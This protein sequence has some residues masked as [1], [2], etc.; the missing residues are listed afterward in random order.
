[1]TPPPILTVKCTR[2]LHAVLVA[3]LDQ[4]Y[5]NAST[6]NSSASCRS[7]LRVL[8]VLGLP[9][10]SR[11][12]N[13]VEWRSQAALR[14]EK[15]VSLQAGKFLFS[16]SLLVPLRYQLADTDCSS[17][18][19]ESIHRTGENCFLVVLMVSCGNPSQHLRCTH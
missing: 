11:K 2:V 8:G 1:M 19:T 17:S 9:L 16:K 6:G 18:H 14:E 3:C 7:T 15:N 5:C 12:V 4:K 13:G 10:L